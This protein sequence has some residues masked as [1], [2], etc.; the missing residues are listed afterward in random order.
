MQRIDPAIARVI[1]WSV[2]VVMTFALSLAAPHL[3]PH[4]PYAVDMMQVNQSPDAEYPFGTDY[5]G[6]C[7]LSRLMYGAATSIF[8]AFP[9]VV[10]TT[11]LGTAIGI[12]SGYFGGKADLLIM[13]FVDTVQAFPSLVFTI[14][15][16]AML[17]GGL[18]N[19]IIALSAIGWTTYARLARSQVLTLKERTYVAAARVSGMSDAQIL[20]RTLLPNSIT[21]VVV[22][23]S[24]HMGN[25]IL[26]FAG[27]SFLGLGTMPP[28]PEWGTMLNDGRA[29][30]QIA[31]WSVAFPGLAI[32]VIV[33]IMGMF[34]DSINA[35][36]NPKKRSEGK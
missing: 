2:V 18:A 25:A 14:A 22:E 33:M 36:F 26:A 15:V 1:A 32:L 17:G 19:C 7:I 28:F 34:G 20:L 13:R 12:L 23:A 30:L 8:A 31:P 5:V 24:M 4:D 6:R 11:I 29:T 10:V 9:V 3:A 35:A 16:A 21:P 27:L